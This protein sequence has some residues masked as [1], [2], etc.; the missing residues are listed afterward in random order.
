MTDRRTD[1]QTDRDKCIV[2]K[3]CGRQTGAD[4]QTGGQT[5][6]HGVFIELLTAAKLGTRCSIKAIFSG[7]GLPITN[8]E[9]WLIHIFNT[10]P[11][12][13]TQCI[14]GTDICDAYSKTSM[15]TSSNGNIFRVTG[16]L[17]GEFTDSPHKG[18]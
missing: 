7:V 17:C 15:M 12:L 13:I 9:N 4:T 3:K 18:Q 14:R 6:R 16:S 1:R 10:K 2:H 8:V 5:Y 11:R